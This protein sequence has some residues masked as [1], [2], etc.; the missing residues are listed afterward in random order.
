M[1][2]SSVY[3][4]PA[5]S[6]TWGRRPW[7]ITSDATEDF[8]VQSPW[9]ISQQ[10]S[11]RALWGRSQ[12]REPMMF[13]CRCRFSIEE[14]YCNISSIFV[15]Q[16][17]QCELLKRMNVP[18]VVL[19]ASLCPWKGCSVC[20]SRVYS[21]WLLGSLERLCN[22]TKLP[23]TPAPGCQGHP[24]KGSLNASQPPGRACIMQ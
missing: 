17:T 8:P 7:V 13:R 4:E 2:G 20:W 15:L 18:S 1:K 9:V 16:L 6:L 14:D 19:A 24:C 3:Q 10:R 5:L 23:A 12:S 21:A 11:E 22:F